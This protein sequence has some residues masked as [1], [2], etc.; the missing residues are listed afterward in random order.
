MIHTSS[1]YCALRRR[2]NLDGLEIPCADKVNAEVALTDSSHAGYIRYSSSSAGVAKLA[3]A[4]DSKWEF[5]SF[6]PFRNCSQQSETT[7]EDYLAA[8]PPLAGLLATF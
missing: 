6:C 1:S 7:R 5:C 8:L 2:L 3:Y 4:A